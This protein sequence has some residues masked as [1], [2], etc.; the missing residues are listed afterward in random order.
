MCCVKRPHPP[1]DT[2]LLSVE[3]LT[4]RDVSTLCVEER[5]KMMG[6][7]QVSVVIVGIRLLEI[8]K[9]K[10]RPYIPIPLLKCE[11]KRHRYRYGRHKYG[12]IL[13]HH[14]GVGVM[15]D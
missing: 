12:S 8:N 1:H 3:N 4:V 11:K 9:G 5:A 14:R 15:R 6:M 7:G 10:K 2:M 13:Q